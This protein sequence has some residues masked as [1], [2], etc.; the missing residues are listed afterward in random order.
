MSDLVVQQLQKY[1]PEVAQ[2]FE[3]DSCI[4]NMSTAELQVIAQDCDALHTD[5]FS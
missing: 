3:E 5:S 4:Y 1:C 2:H